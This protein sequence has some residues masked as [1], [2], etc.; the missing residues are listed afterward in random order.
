MTSNRT[1]TTIQVERCSQPSSAAKMTHSGTLAVSLVEGDLIKLVL[2][3]GR[4][5]GQGHGLRGVAQRTVGG[6]LARCEVEREGNRRIQTRKQMTNQPN[7]ERIALDAC[8][9]SNMSK[10][11]ERTSM[12][13]VFQP[14]AG[15]L[16]T[17]VT[18]CVALLVKD[19]TCKQPDNDKE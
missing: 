6:G 18:T 8:R 5:V 13:Y 19:A 11:S 4:S 15:R 16:A 12:W 7:K 10:S 17:K 3:D 1:V 2:N 14:T 9:P